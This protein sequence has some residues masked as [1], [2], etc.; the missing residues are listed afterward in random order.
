MH[1]TPSLEFRRIS[2]STVRESVSVGEVPEL[3][4]GLLKRCADKLRWEPQDRAVFLNMNIDTIEAKLGSKAWELQVR[5]LCHS[6]GVTADHLRFSER[7]N[8]KRC[9]L[10]FGRVGEVPAHWADLL[11]PAVYMYHH[12]FNCLWVDIPEFGSDAGRYLQY[13]PTLIAGVLRFLCVKSVCAVACGVGGTLFL[14]MLPMFPELF[15]RTHVVYNLNCPP[16]PVI[17][18]EVLRIE[19]LLRKDAL[20]LWFAYQDEPPEYDRISEGMPYQTYEVVYKMQ[21]RLENERRRGRRSLEYDEVLISETVNQPRVTHISH[22]RIGKHELHVFSD[23]FLNSIVRYLNLKPGARQTHVDD[24]LGLVPDFDAQAVKGM[25]SADGGPTELPAVRMLRLAPS[26]EERLVVAE[27]NRRRFDRF[28][29]ASLCLTASPELLALGSHESSLPALPSAGRSRSASRLDARSLPSAGAS[30]STSRL[31][32]SQMASEEEDLQIVESVTG[33]PRI[34]RTKSSG[35]LQH[36]RSGTPAMST[37]MVLAAS[38]RKLSR[39]E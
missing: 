2:S 38:A 9:I 32:L 14:E 29:A 24:A 1:L 37:A 5:S 39:H 35:E 16:M 15:G 25:I 31:Q 4:I 6:R 28:Q 8:M 26:N 23:E 12:Q 22:V 7:F 13:G 33:R 30:R 19:E 21:A 10:L 3:E 17:P 18:F 27:A 11:Q 34:A 20:Q 36:T